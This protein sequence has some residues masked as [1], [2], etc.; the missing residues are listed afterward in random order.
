MIKDLFTRLLNEDKDVEEYIEELAT[1]E[2]TKTNN[3]KKINNMVENEYRYRKTKEELKLM[4]K[5]ELI[6]FNLKLMKNLREMKNNIL[7]INSE[8][9]F[10]LRKANLNIKRY[11]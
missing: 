5:V 9:N 6:K 3:K 11:R 2:K 7:K 1:I 4:K 10:L 8:R